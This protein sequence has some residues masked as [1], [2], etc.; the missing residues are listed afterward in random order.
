[1]AG[2]QVLKELITPIS[3]GGNLERHGRWSDRPE[4]SNENSD[5]PIP[6]TWIALR[7]CM[8]LPEAYTGTIELQNLAN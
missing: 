8:T 2:R 4:K 7:T 3:L 1:M 5:L 6:A